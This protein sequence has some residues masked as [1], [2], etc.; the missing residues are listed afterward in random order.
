MWAERSRLRVC[1]LLTRGSNE[2]SFA[3]LS[4]SSCHLEKPSAIVP[5]GTSEKS[6]RSRA[7]AQATARVFANSF[8]LAGLSERPLVLTM[9]A[10]ACLTLLH[11]MKL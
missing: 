3:C 1:S 10:R 2:G 8:S 7:S 11:Q 4:Q 6:S 5:R 9:S